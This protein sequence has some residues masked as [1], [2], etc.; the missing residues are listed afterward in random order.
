VIG[1]TTPEI[2][3]GDT[4]VIL[5]ACLVRSV[6]S[7]LCDP[8]QQG[9]WR[10]IDEGIV[11]TEVLLLAVA[12]DDALG[13]DGKPGFTLL[14][15]GLLAGRLRAPDACTQECG[16]SVGDEHGIVGEPLLHLFASGGLGRFGGDL[17]AERVVPVE[18]HDTLAD[19]PPRNDGPFTQMDD[20]PL[21]GRVD[22]AA[23]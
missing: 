13:V 10:S 12:V 15:L 8:V 9:A 19:S 4:V 23:V 20:K 7:G 17:V 18:L 14:A 22:V 2:V 3:T 11:R 1:P 21:V 16:S 5:V 6:P